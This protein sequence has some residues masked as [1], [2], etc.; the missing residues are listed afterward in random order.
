MFFE[1]IVKKNIPVKSEWF[2]RGKSGNNSTNLIPVDFQ[3][4]AINNMGIT[5]KIPLILRASFSI[6]MNDIDS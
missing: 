6:L 3:K 2:G 1:G 4:V 5:A